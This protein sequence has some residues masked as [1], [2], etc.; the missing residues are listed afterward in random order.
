MKKCIVLILAAMLLLAMS[1]SQV[2]KDYK[3]QSYKKLA[4]FAVYPATEE[5]EIGSVG[6]V[7]KEIV[8]GIAEALLEDDPAWLATTELA[9][10]SSRCGY[11]V[12]LVGPEDYF[13]NRDRE[14]E[15]VF[16]QRY[17][18]NLPDDYASYRHKS[19]TYIPANIAP[20]A[21]L[22]GFATKNGDDEHV[23]I[24]LRKWVGDKVLFRMD[25]DYFLKH[26]NEFFC[27]ADIE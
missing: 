2:P 21:Y 25:Y 7:F 20:D 3:P 10:I 4:V 13:D 14:P 9:V 8:T 18:D 5:V 6:D 17:S 26:Y 1:C 15:V 11:D 23:T 22:T 12:Y 24:E 19:K 16:Q 27:G